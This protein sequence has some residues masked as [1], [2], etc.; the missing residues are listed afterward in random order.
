MAE[1]KKLPSIKYLDFLDCPGTISIANMV[2]KTIIFKKHQVKRLE[3][4][5]QDSDLR[6]K[7]I[8]EYFKEVYENDDFELMKNQ[9]LDT[10]E[11]TAINFIIEDVIFLRKNQ[12]TN[13]HLKEFGYKKFFQN[14]K[15]HNKK[16]KKW[17]RRG[18]KNLRKGYYYNC[19]KKFEIPSGH[20]EA[21]YKAAY[22]VFLQ[23]FIRH[24]LI[25]KS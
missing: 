17:L 8:L 3:L 16:L 4:S 14:S 10:D 25:V 13:S 9:V 12:E 18:I 7:K 6:I 5:F 15:V 24:Y 2:Y 21:Y 11:K 1:N 22:L 19:D 23:M 20:K